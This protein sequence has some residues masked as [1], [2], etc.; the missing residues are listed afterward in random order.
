MSAT[1]HRSGPPVS[2]GGGVG[3]DT[4]RGGGGF[5]CSLTCR[6]GKK[7]FSASPRNRPAPCVGC[8]W[9]GAWRVASVGCPGLG[10][11][12]TTRLGPK[13]RARA[14]GGVSQVRRGCRGTA[15]ELWSS[16]PSYPS[17]LLWVGGGGRGCCS[18]LALLK[19]FKFI[20]RCEE[21]RETV[22]ARYVLRVGSPP[23]A[24][25]A[26]RL[27]LYRL[28]TSTPTLLLFN[29]TLHFLTPPAQLT[30][31]PTPTP[32]LPETPYIYTHSRYLAARSRSALALAPLLPPSTRRAV[33]RP[34]L[35][36]P[37]PVPKQ[38]AQC[39]NYCNM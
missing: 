5:G 18:A 6:T 13:L 11:R 25:L 4:T 26:S 3:R 15:V 16:G 10:P 17:E 28:S 2:G 14:P 30:I 39:V 29:S 37:S 34:G 27:T 12:H 38:C 22:E 35:Q 8:G 7:G 20:L 36:P 31:I 24:R 9:R 33:G 1:A 32:T 23:L 19:K 21:T